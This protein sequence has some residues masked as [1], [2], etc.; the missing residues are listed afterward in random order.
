MSDGIERWRIYTA[1]AIAATVAI[2][3]EAGSAWLLWTAHTGARG[4]TGFLLCHLVACLIMA[5]VFTGLLSSK[6]G[7]WKKGTPFVVFSLCFFIPWFGM[8]GMIAGVL[9]AL[10][11]PRPGSGA[12]RLSAWSYLS[13][14]PLPDQSPS[15]REPGTLHFGVASIAGILQGASDLGQRQKGVLATLQLRDNE[16]IGL[17]R[18]A[19]RDPEDDVRLLA[20]ALL[21]RKE[22]A[23]TAR[24]R[25][26]QKRLDSARGD[27]KVSHH[28]AIAFDCWELIHLGLVQGE[29]MNYLLATAREHAE[30][31][32]RRRPKNPGLEFLLGKVLARMGEPELASDALRRAENLGIDSE[33]ISPYMR[34]VGFWQRRLAESAK[35]TSISAA[36][37]ATPLPDGG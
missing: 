13:I 31:A 30:A 9:P 27:Q 15:P 28:S 6:H 22:Q 7:S 2:S 36:G 8:L 4:L 26:H 3:L 10:W 20:Y 35:V 29:V 16:A 34:E 25:L 1:E 23:I 5:S 12:T 33:I 11:W 32:L 18:R 19:L 14:P 17:L 21:D 24:I 37:E